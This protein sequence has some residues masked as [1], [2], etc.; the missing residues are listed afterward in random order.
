MEMS[1]AEFCRAKPA[2]KISFIK[3][4]NNYKDRLIFDKI[5]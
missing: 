2:G 5:K 1:Q 4:A 3:Y